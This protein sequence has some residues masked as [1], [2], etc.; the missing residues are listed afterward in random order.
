MDFDL[1]RSFIADARQACRD[2]NAIHEPL[3]SEPELVRLLRAARSSAIDR[4]GRFATESG[5]IY[6]YHVHGAGYSFNEIANGKEIHFDV[7]SVD[8]VPRIRFSAWSVI[9][10]VGGVDTV[11]SMEVVR[12]ELDRLGA[13]H[14][15]LMHVTEGGLDYYLWSGE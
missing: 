13:D 12:S 9:Q 1:L 10:Y 14:H 3:G 11:A 5:R 6:D 2:W 8:G 4:R 15:E 7:V